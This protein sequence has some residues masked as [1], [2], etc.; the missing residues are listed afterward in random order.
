VN[1]IVAALAAKLDV[2]VP[3]QPWQLSGSEH[4]LEILRQDARCRGP[5]AAALPVTPSL[6]LWCFG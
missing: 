5:F 1:P 4:R 2:I 6:I 3:N